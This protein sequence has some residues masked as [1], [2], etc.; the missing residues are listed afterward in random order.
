[1]TRKQFRRPFNSTRHKSHRD[2][3]KE[4]NNVYFAKLFL[5]RDSHAET[6][7]L[8][9][10]VFVDG[11]HVICLDVLYN[12]NIMYIDFHQTFYDICIL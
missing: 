7:N 9:T 2:Q 6:F 8:D 1:M 4:K 5:Y 10:K 12:H 3:E 11:I